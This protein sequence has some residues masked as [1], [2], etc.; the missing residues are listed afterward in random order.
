[1]DYGNSK[2]LHYLEI[3]NDAQVL[4]K[5]FKKE[6][7]IE[8]MVITFLA[9]YTIFYLHCLYNKKSINIELIEVKNVLFY[10]SKMSCTGCGIIVLA[11]ASSTY[12]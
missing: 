1:V 11:F 10:S 7:F 2:T 9:F 5:H 4:Y 6:H 3:I 12:N 8:K